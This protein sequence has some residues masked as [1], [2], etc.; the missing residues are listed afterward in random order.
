MFREIIQGAGYLE[1]YGN[2]P[3]NGIMLGFIVIGAIGG[4]VHGLAGAFIGGLLMTITIGPMWIVG[5][6]SR[7][8]A[9]KRSKNLLEQL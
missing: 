4:G 1:D 7:A 8:R 2:H 6:I 5:C 3:G 9:Y